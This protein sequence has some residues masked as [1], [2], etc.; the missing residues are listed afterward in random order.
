MDKRIH[1]LLKLTVT[2]GAFL[3]GGP[4]ASLGIGVV[5]SDG[6]LHMVID[7]GQ[8]FRSVAAYELR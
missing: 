1:A 7:G 5:M 6:F 3:V 2:G 8:A 4:L